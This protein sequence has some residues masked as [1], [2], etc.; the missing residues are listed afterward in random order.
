MREMEDKKVNIEE[1]LNSL[2][3]EEAVHNAIYAIAGKIE[4]PEEYIETAIDFFSDR[5][6]YYKGV[7]IARRT[8]K[9]DLGKKLFQKQISLEEKTKNYHGVLSDIE[10]LDM[11]KEVIKIYLRIMRAL[12][13]EKDYAKAMEVSEKLGI[14]LKAEELY[15]KIINK[16]VQNQNYAKAAEFAEKKGR[17]SDAIEFYEKT[18]KSYHIEKAGDLAKEKRNYEKSKELYLKALELQMKE[19]WR[20]SSYRDIARVAEKLGKFDVAFAYLKKRAFDDSGD[21]DLLKKIDELSKKIG[22]ENEAKEIFEYQI[23]EVEEDRTI[24]STSY[25]IAAQIADMAGLKDKA[26]KLRQLDGIV[27][28]PYPTKSN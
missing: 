11:N 9:E 14:K 24:H 18:D 6:E 2:E 19:E 25:S 17:I 7:Q 8:G 15:S 28:M 21:I 13:K 27:N 3:S 16:F 4:I 5:K 12:E 20:H 1:I 23:L 10:G 22:F 26:E